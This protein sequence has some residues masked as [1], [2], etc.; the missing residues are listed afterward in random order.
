MMILIQD[1]SETAGTGGS[2]DFVVKKKEIEVTPP[3]NEDRPKKLALEEAACD[4][5]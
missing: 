2:P 3:S 4:E 1:V 5:L